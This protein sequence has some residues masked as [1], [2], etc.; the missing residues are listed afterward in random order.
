[1]R[2]LV[3]KYYVEFDKHYKAQIKELMA[4]GQSEEE[5]KKNAPVML[6]AQEMLRKWEARDP[7]V[8]SLW[9]TMNGWVYEGFDV[10]YKALG[11][12]FD[13]V[14]YESQ[15]Y[16]LGKSLVEEGLRKGVFYRRPDNS[17]WIDLTADGLDEKLLLRGDGTS[18]Y[19]TQDLGT[20]YRR[21]EDNKL[22]DMIYVVGNE[23][24]YHFQVLKLVLK[25]LGYA[26]W[27]DHITH[28]SY[29]MVEL[30]EGKMKSREGTVVDADDL[31]AGMVATAREMSAELG[32][33][34]GCS[35]DSVKSLTIR[36]VSP[37]LK[38]MSTVSVCVSVG[39]MPSSRKKIVNLLPSCLKAFI[40]CAAALRSP[41]TMSAAEATPE[42][43]AVA[44]CTRL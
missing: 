43:V 5:A 31:I 14:Y 12:D 34:D 40:T 6:E 19:M 4:Q 2:R 39:T 9:E 28:L 23:Q 17:V 20:A 42:S 8:Y 32:K 25:K 11:V 44:D 21:F 36:C 13:K 22:D 15:T 35:E 41:V 10:T 24:N 16:L 29:G 18:V 3:G 1:M 27:S 37:L 7:E 38:V 33:L 26:D 30:P